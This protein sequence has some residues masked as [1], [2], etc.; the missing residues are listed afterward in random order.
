[1]ALQMPLRQLRSAPIR[2]LRRWIQPATCSSR[3]YFRRRKRRDPQSWLKQLVRKL[4]DE[5][6]SRA[7]VR[8]SLRRRFGLN[9]TI[10]VKMDKESPD[11]ADRDGAA[12]DSQF[13]GQKIFLFVELYWSAD[14]LH[15]RANA[16]SFFRLRAQVRSDVGIHY[17]VWASDQQMHTGRTAR[18]VLGDD[19]LD[20]SGQSGFARRIIGSTKTLSSRG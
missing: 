11:V 7:S 15:R 20:G 9:N 14:D 10:T 1:M 5:I 8:I 17:T 19:F 4:I 18:N 16:Q 2:S 13:A 6:S 3:C 12:V